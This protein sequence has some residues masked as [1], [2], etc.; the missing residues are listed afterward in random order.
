MLSKKLKAFKEKQSHFFLNDYDR[1]TSVSKM[2]KELNLDSI[3]LRRKVKQL[4]RMHTIA[5][6]KFFYG[7]PENKLI[8]EIESNLN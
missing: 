6:Q 5:S 4:K 2:I 3:R 8:Q 7:M 1:D